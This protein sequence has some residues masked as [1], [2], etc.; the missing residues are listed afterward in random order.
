MARSFALTPKI[1]RSGLESR[2]VSSATEEE[3]KNI[4]GNIWS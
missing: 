1:I 4:G 3:R 2:K